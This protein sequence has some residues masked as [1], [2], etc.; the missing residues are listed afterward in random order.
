VQVVFF[1]A[2]EERT[3][4]SWA[5]ARTLAPGAPVAVVNLE[6][7]GASDELAWIPEDGFALRRWQSPEELVALVNGA[8]RELRGAELPPRELPFGT[9]TDGRSFLAHGIPALTLRAFTGESFPRRLHSEHDSRDRL[10][11]PAIERC[12]ELL[13]ALVRRSDAD[14]GRVASAILAARARSRTR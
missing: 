12:A 10:S 6:S 1:A 8:A 7:V 13:L 14:P 3:L 9:L 5:F 11:L 4:G 2:E